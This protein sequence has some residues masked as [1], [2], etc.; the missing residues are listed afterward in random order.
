MDE[1]QAKP[2]SPASPWTWLRVLYAVLALA[3]FAFPGGMVDW[4][5][6]RNTDG[7]LAAPL[8][9]ARGVDAASAAIGVKQVGQGLRKWFAAAVG[10]ADS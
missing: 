7:W 5:D 10:D 1:P 4:L 2:Q 6:E 8:A 3:A 9:I